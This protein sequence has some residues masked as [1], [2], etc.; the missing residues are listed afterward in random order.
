MDDSL[1]LPY[2]QGGSVLGS[3]GR[4]RNGTVDRNRSVTPYHSPTDHLPD[5]ILSVPSHNS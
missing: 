1:L 4:Q 5:Q 3:E 2:F